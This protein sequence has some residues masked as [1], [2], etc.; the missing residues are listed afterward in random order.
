MSVKLPQIRSLCVEFPA[1]HTKK[2]PAA[3]GKVKK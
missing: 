2:V 3:Q 1:H